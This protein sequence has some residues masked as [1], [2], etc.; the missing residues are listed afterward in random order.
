[1]DLRTHRFY[2][3]LSNLGYNQVESSNVLLKLVKTQQTGFEICSNLICLTI[4]QAIPRRVFQLN[5]TQS[6]LTFVQ[7]KVIELSSN[8]R[9]DLERIAFCVL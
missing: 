2:K 1:M 9:I 6:G 8:Y 7:Y 4:G 5:S 3:T